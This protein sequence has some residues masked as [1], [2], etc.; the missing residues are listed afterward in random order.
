[1]GSSSLSLCLGSYTPV[2]AVVHASASMEIMSDQ[3]M[4]VM[5]NGAE[6]TEESPLTANYWA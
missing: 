4:V 6:M 5:M 3:N 1:M 2:M